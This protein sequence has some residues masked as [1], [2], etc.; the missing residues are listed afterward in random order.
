MCGFIDP[1]QSGRGNS[2]YSVGVEG[3]LAE[4]LYETTTRQ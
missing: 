2:V 3:Y 1:G 4:R